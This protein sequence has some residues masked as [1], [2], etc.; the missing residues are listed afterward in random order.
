MMIKER[1]D[2]YDD[3]REKKE[4]PLKTAKKSP[5]SPHCRKKYRAKELPALFIFKDNAD[6]FI[7]RRTFN[8]KIC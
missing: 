8:D 7:K 1:I 4:K 5:L 2:Q 6:L 3:K